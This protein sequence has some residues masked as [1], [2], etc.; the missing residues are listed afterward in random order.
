MLLGHLDVQQLAALVVYLESR[1][2]QVEMVVQHPL[3]SATRGVA[4][5]LAD[6]QF[7]AARAPITPEN[8]R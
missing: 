2:V 4:V 6:A 1:V 3:E 5:V 8:Q 7:C